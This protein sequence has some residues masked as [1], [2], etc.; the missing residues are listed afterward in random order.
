MDNLAYISSPVF[1]EHNPG[2]FHPERPGR[3][4]AIENHLKQSGAWDTFDHFDAP[5]ASH[6]QLCLAHQPSLVDFN[7]LQR[8]KESIM[9]DQGDTV[10]SEKSIDAAEKAAG[11]CI[12]AV[13]L[14]LSGQFKRAF[15]AVRPPG[16]HAE[17]N[18]SMGF[19]VF[20]NIAV[21]ASYAVKKF[22]LK[23]ILIIDWD[24]HHGNGTQDIFYGRNDVFYLSFHQVPLFPGTGYENETGRGIGRGCTLNYPLFAGKDDLFYTDL[25]NKALKNIEEIFK[26]EIILISAGFDAHESDPIGGM[27]LTDNGFAKM[28]E[29]V[30]DFANKYCNERI[31]SVLEGGY[32][33]NGLAESVGAHLKVLKQ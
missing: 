26:P 20:N 5:V 2:L 30:V 4:S 3:L 10:L 24:V 17:Y 21:A 18:R 19:C 23:K 9:L 15:A 33:L 13:E 12:K 22:A 27:K 14:I 32:N 29:I 11:A 28:T 1:P 6:D 8:G 25:L 7:L 31:I 16:H